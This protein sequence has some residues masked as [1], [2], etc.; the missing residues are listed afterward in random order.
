M[1]IIT[2]LFSNMKRRLREFTCR[3][4][5]ST[6]TG[7]VSSWYREAAA[8]DAERAK[9]AVRDEDFDAFDD[10]TY[11]DTEIAE[12][13]KDKKVFADVE[14]LAPDC[15]YDD[16]MRDFYSYCVGEK[17]NPFTYEH[18]YLVQEVLY[19]ICGEWEDR[20]HDVDS[21]KDKY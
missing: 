2:S 11:S 19:E 3:A 8:L 14:D 6:A 7:A 4:L 18:D 9:N 10:L 21:L 13:Y 16:M 20:P 1:R 17:E 5:R 15:R 12:T